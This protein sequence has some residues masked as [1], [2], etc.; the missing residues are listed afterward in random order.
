MIVTPTAD[1]GGPSKGPRVVFAFGMT[2]PDIAADP[3]QAFS[4]V[5]L[6]AAET[7]DLP[8]LT[9]RIDHKWM[10]N[11]PQGASPVAG[12]QDL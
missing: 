10:K 3:I 5:G 2:H 4:Q 9:K 8:T 7:I 6:P 12:K 1:E 11:K